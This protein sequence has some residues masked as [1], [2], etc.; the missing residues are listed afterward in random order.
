MDHLHLSLLVRIHRR[1]SRLMNYGFREFSIDAPRDLFIG[2]LAESLFCPRIKSQRAN[3]KPDS[4]YQLGGTFDGR[5][6]D[7]TLPLTVTEGTFVLFS[8]GS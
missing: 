2:H 8:C 4:N 1:R 3:P 5:V 7:V 6:E